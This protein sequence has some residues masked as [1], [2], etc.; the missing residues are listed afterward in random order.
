[1]YKAK[2]LKIFFNHA[3]ITYSRGIT[4]T[5][6][7]SLTESREP[8]ADFWNCLSMWNST[9]HYSAPQIPVALTLLNSN[10]YLLNPV[11]LFSRAF[12]LFMLYWGMCLLENTKDDH[13]LTIYVSLS[14]N[15]S[16]WN[17]VFQNL[18]PSILYVLIY[19]LLIY[20]RRESRKY[21]LC[22]CL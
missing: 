13:R 6:H 20:Y 2:A 15:S 12:F 5:V 1:M 19:F 7:Y 21:I 18:N 3:I 9:I 14:E 4:I 22:F 11:R 16:L 10:L 8:W 17:H